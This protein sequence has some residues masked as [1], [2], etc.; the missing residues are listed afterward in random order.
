MTEVLK[1]AMNAKNDDGVA[2]K[3]ILADK[4]SE[5]LATGRVTFGDKVIEGT[6]SDWIEFLK[7]FYNHTDGPVPQQVDVDNAGEV[8][9]RIVYENS[10]DNSSPEAATLETD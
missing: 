10:R 2:Y 8:V 9:M 6:L 5:L 4:V 1:T 7:W 3:R